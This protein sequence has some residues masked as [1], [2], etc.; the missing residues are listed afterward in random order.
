[1]K[2]FYPISDNG[3]YVSGYALTQT[4]KELVKIRRNDMHEYLSV[5]AF[6]SPPSSVLHWMKRLRV[7]SS[8]RSV[9]EVWN[10]LK[11]PLNLDIPDNAFISSLQISN[12]IDENHF[13]FEHPKT[14]T[15]HGAVFI[16][17]YG[18]V[19][20]NLMNIKIKTFRTDIF[21]LFNVLNLASLMT[22]LRVPSALTFL[23]SSSEED[24]T[25]NFALFFPTKED[26]GVLYGFQITPL[27][28]SEKRITIDTPVEKLLSVNHR[29]PKPGSLLSRLKR[30]SV[31]DTCRSPPEVQAWLL[32]VQEFEAPNHDQMLNMIRVPNKI[33]QNEFFVKYVLRDFRST[34]IYVNQSMEGS[35]TEPKGVV[36]DKEELWSLFRTQGIF[37]LMTKLAVDKP[38]EYPVEQELSSFR[39]SIDNFLSG[40]SKLISLSSFTEAD[41]VRSAGRLFHLLRAGN[42]DI[43]GGTVYRV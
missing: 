9:D 31:P 21:P 28:I 16:D 4:T 11:R 41:F 35:L 37:S 43:R 23:V 5:N 20:E 6:F 18:R 2:L 30:I 24:Q 1:M 42:L 22:K 15:I 8:L 19:S 3:D 17:Q 27:E 12:T 39:S 7:P 29:V 36:V 26:G 14:G 10:W 33:Y 38:L 32:D 40:D 34:T 13:V 25:Q